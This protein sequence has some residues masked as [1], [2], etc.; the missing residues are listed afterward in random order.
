M[1]VICL[2]KV[3]DNFTLPS[4]W[5]AQSDLLPRSTVWDL[6]KMNYLQGRK[7]IKHFR[8]MIEVTSTVIN[9]FHSTF[10]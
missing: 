10:V 5:V 4:L 1:L 9:L 6:G 7:L 2:Q 3:E 8:E